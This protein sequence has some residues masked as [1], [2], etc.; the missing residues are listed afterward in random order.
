M[1]EQV[2]VLIIDDEPDIL[3]TIKEICDFCG[4]ET[5][6]TTSGEEGFQIAKKQNPQLI[7]VDYHMPGWDGMT[8]VKKM[9]TLDHNMAILVLTVDER[10]EI[11]DKFMSA[12]ATDFAIKPIKAPDLMSRIKVNLHIQSIQEKMI[13]K[14]EQVFIEKGISS[15]T[16]KLVLEYLDTQEDLVGMEDITKGVNLAYQTV[17]RYLQYLVEQDQVDVVPVYGQLGRPKNQYKIKE[18]G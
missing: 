14:K 1:S 10:Q 9:K 3:F 6:T 18:K 5:F 11:S 17:H 8:T 12:G 15:A 7:I 13:Q 4:Y 16:L 2:K